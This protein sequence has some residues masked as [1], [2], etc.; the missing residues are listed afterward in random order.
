MGKDKSK[1]IFFAEVKEFEGEKGKYCPGAIFKI[2]FGAEFK[3]SV[4]DDTDA[5]P[6]TFNLYDWS[7]V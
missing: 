4:A 3:S 2:L 7:V 6:R 1:L 5:E